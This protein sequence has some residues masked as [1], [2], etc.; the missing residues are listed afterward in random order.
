MQSSA[1]TVE[2]YLAELPEDRRA[3]VEAVREVVTANLPEG[4]AESMGWGMI[5]YS[6]PLERYP[7]TYNGQPLSYLGIAAQKR[8]YAVYLS[9]VYSD[10]DLEAKLRKRWAPPSGRKIDLGKSC[11]RFPKLDDV[12]LPLLG[13]VVAAVPVD[14]FIEVYEAARAK[15]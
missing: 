6:V 5:G 7:D 9:G 12:D 14:R 2:D 15:R 11:L 3:V 10:S 13:E 4:Y 1:A 8:H